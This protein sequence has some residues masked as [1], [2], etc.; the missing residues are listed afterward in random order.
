MARAAAALAAGVRAGRARQMR[1]AA[2]L[3][4]APIARRNAQAGQA[5]ATLAARGDNALDR[6]LERARGRLGQAERLL[7]TLKLSEAA[8]LERG[9][10]L[11]RG[12]DGLVI[13]R[14]AEIGAGAALTLQFADGTAEA[15]AGHG[16]AGARAKP[17]GRK[18]APDGGQGTLF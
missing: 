15:V 7:S 18:P 3:T 16:A 17:A 9:Y 4:I 6:R 8:I 11:V 10:A 13:R 5:L 14:A 1:G 2:R 12:A